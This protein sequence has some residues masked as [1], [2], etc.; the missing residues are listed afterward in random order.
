MALYAA[1]DLARDR[2]GWQPRH[3]DIV[4]IVKSAVDWDAKYVDG[5][6]ASA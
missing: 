6:A 3:L 2:L 4:E 5:L 1:N